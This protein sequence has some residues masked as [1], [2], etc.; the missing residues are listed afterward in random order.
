MNKNTYT[1]GFG[2]VKTFELLESCTVIDRTNCWVG[3]YFSFLPWT[4]A[5]IYC[6]VELSHTCK[7]RISCRDLNSVFLVPTNTGVSTIYDFLFYKIMHSFLWFQVQVQHFETL[8]IRA[9]LVFWS[10]G[11]DPGQILSWPRVCL[12]SPHFVFCTGIP[13]NQQGESGRGDNR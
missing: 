9:G 2:V 6:L 8:V 12:F 10:I 3:V 13:H 1:M 5:C 7:M 4:S 11:S